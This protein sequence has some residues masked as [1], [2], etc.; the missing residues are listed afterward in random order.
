[1][2]SRDL[3]SDQDPPAAA[4]LYLSAL[5]HEQHY[6]AAE[7]RQAVSRAQAAT[8]GRPAELARLYRQSTLGADASEY[9]VRAGRR[10]WALD[11]ARHLALDEG[12]PADAEPPAWAAWEE[13]VT[14]FLAAPHTPSASSSRH[15]A[16]PS[17]PGPRQTTALRELRA[18]RRRPARV[19]AAVVIA[20]MAG[21][22]LANEAPGVMATAWAGPLNIGLTLVLAQVVC[23]GWAVLWY[24]RYARRRLEPLV[25]RHRASF[26]HLES[27]R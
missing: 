1:M 8:G 11:M 23:T 26:P 16:P 19:A 9:D 18:A 12:R 27:P 3:F 13:P 15:A 5:D 4:A 6:S 2:D 22:V 24:A 17:Y 7:L 21:V 25:E 10:S 20:Q 14:A